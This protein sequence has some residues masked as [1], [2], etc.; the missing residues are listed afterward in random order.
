MDYPIKILTQE[1]A[2]VLY[3]I[4]NIKINENAEG[5]LQSKLGKL[6]L[7]VGGV[8]QEKLT[9]EDTIEKVAEKKNIN[10]AGLSSV[11]SKERELFIKLFNKGFNE[12]SDANKT[13]F[14][15]T[16]KINGLSSDQVASITVLGGIG[17]AQCSGFG[18]YL[19]ASSTAA[20]I[21]GAF[22][23]TLSF[24][25]YT[26]M[27]GFIKFA[28]GP[29]GFLLAAIPLFK[30]FKNFRSWQDFKNIFNSVYSEGKNYFV[31]NYQSAELVIQYFASLRIMKLYQFETDLSQIEEDIKLVNVDKENLIKSQNE[32]S[33]I[34]EGRKSELQALEIKMT[35][36]KEVVQKLQ[37][38]GKE[39]ERKLSVV[40]LEEIETQK[41][42][43]ELTRQIEFIKTA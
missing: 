7:P 27:S 8:L 42:R 36:I 38:S 6:L 35:S 39:L 1:E 26:A 32:L 23:I 37:I 13:E 15:E 25:F 41:N 17:I 24:A 22:G 16:L 33:V 20:A 5:K 12:L 21:T 30:T 4:F 31:G 10:L 34:L 2:R 19:L 14:L 43:Q 11:A 28:I 40:D 29:V 18:I 9:Y 3:K